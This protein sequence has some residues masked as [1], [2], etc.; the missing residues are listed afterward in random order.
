MKIYNT[1]T[2]ELEEFKPITP[3]KVTFYQCGPTVYSYQHIGNLTSAVKGDQI[4]RA[5][6]YLGYEVQYTRNIT[7]V[8]HLVSDED[9]G[10]DKIAKG[11]RREG[12][13]PEEITKKYTKIYHEDLEKLNV[14]APDHE[15]IA[16]EYIDQMADLVQN[17]IDKGYAYATELAIYFE[18]DKF[19]RYNELNRQNLEK[20]IQGAGHGEKGDPGKKKPYDFAVWF[21]K[22]GAHENALQ[23]WN[24]KFDG[25]KQPTE[26]GFPGWHIECSAMAEDTLGQPID[27]HMG[28]VEHIQVH[29]TNEIAQSECGY[30]RKFVNYWLH[31]EMLLI[32]GGK[33]SKSKGSVYTIKD[34]E[35]KGFDPLDFRY[36]LLQ[37]HYRSKQ[38]FTWEA[39]EAAKTAREKLVRGLQNLDLPENVILDMIQDPKSTDNNFKQNFHE[40]LSTDFNI[41]Q[42]LAVVWEVLKAQD[43]EPQIKLA[44]ILNFDEVLGLNLK[45]QISNGKQTPKINPE[46]QKMIKEREKA[47]AEK[48]FPKADEIRNRLKNEFDVEIEDTAE[49]TKII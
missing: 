26:E 6:A 12:L 33:M 16:T 13:T 44:T 15:T 32:D 38:N 29:H 25:I 41:P 8:G 46:I 30:G 11:A 18:V 17:L 45:E 34:L 27:I 4:R 21:F 42:A 49:G 1:L 28:G 7:D 37:A 3:P 19:D 5:L 20:N 36:F 24:K 43:I 40:A 14:L 31:H 48:N 39:L 23:T 9:E 22:A 10:E 35:D 47:R 2:R